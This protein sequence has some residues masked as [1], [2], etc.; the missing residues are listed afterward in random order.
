MRQSPKRVRFGL[1]CCVLLFA[2]DDP[3]EDRF[4]RAGDLR[5]MIG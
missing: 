4:F 2:A 1:W 5:K 3:A